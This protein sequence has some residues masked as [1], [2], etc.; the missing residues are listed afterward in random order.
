MEE[1][2]PELLEDLGMKFPTENSK[3]KT[4]YGLYE[5][6]FCGN[7]FRALTNNIKRGT[8]KSCGCLTTATHGLTKHRMYSIWRGMMERCYNMSKVEYKN[9]GGRCIS[10]CE[11]WHNIEN[12]IE[13]MVPS[14]EEGLTLDRINV[15]GNYEPD[16]CRWA[17]KS[18]QTQNTRRLR[19]TNKSGYRGVS[20]DKRVCKWR[21]QIAV[22]NKVKH[23]GCFT[24]PE[25]AARVYDQY[26]IDNNL[27]HTK[28]FDY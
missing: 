9:Y 20:W 16:N 26:I 24:T 4:R 17:D 5:C 28:N 15:D 22:N 19:S 1:K 7:E 25:E 14:F 13:D 27:E 11:R 3:Q 12:F 8:T 10:V 18:T 21:V 6:P 23:L 2:V